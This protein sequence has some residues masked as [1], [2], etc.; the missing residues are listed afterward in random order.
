MNAAVLERRIVL[1]SRL[2][3][4]AAWLLVALGALLWW[5]CAQLET[6]LFLTAGIVGIGY[7]LSREQAMRLRDTLVDRPSA[8]ADAKLP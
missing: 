2:F 6:A 5:C 1:V 7:F 8:S 4:L 3:A